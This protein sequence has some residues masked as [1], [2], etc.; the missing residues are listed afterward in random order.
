MLNINCCVDDS[1]GGALSEAKLGIHYLS[2]KGVW[3]GKRRIDIEFD[4]EVKVT[5]LH[6]FG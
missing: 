6:R 1:N 3:L 5:I 2:L 4:E